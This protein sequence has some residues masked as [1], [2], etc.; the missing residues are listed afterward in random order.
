MVFKRLT[1]LWILAP[2]SRTLFLLGIVLLI[3]PPV[4]VK[5]TAQEPPP[6]FPTRVGHAGL[7]RR[8]I[9]LA[10]W[11]GSRC[12]WQRLRGRPLQPP[13]PDVWLSRLGWRRCC[14]CH[15]SLSWHPCEGCRRQRLLRQPGRS[16]CRR[17]PGA[18]SGGP[19]DCTGEVDQCADTDL[20]ETVVID[21]CDSG[22]PNTVLTGCSI[23]DLVGQCAAGATNHGRFVSCVSHLTNDLKKD[24]VISGEQKGAI[25]DCAGQADIP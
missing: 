3:A 24:G 1:Q 9:Q 17:R 14:R 12:F 8:A 6:T 18:P 16:R 25:Q 7:R 5:A 22:V 19:S 13:D 20:S 2:R 21:S 10:V 23:S 4:A 11:C 15:R